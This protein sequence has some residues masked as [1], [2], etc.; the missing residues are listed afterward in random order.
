MIIPEHETNQGGDANHNRKKSMKLHIK[1]LITTCFAVILGSMLGRQTCL[2]NEVVNTINSGTAVLTTNLVIGYSFTVGSQPLAVDALGVWAPT[3]SG[4]L[5]AHEVG[6]W[7]ISAGNTLVASTT[8]PSGAGA[9]GGFVWSGTGGFW[10]ETIAATPLTA[11]DT[12]M[13]GA[14]YSATTS[15]RALIQAGPITIDPN[16]ASTGDASFI[17]SATLQ[18]PNNIVPSA[19]DGYYGPNAEI[20][21]V[22]EPMPCAMLGLGLLILSWFRRNRE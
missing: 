10:Y 19:N 18:E 9:N 22:P 6:L 11:G 16:I 1:L 5:D 7:D 15:D 8:V 12:Y 3:N 13:L 20:T 2:G 4:L 17:L 14:L 21:V